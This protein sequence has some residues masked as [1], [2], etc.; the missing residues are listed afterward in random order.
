M[1]QNC[2]FLCADTVQS[3]TRHCMATQRLRLVATDSQHRCS[4]CKGRPMLHIVFYCSAL[5]LNGHWKTHCFGVLHYKSCRP[6]LPL[7]ETAPQ[8][9]K[10]FYSIVNLVAIPSKLQTGSWVLHRFRTVVLWPCL[11]W[12]FQWRRKLILPKDR[13][14]GHLLKGRTLKWIVFRDALTE[15][16]EQ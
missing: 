5:S 8:A 1:L 11:F 16:M 6:H 13:R 4:R 2:P 7:V 12:C 14:S 10:L 3:G 9:L 15:R